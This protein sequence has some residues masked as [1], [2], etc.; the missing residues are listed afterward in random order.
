VRILVSKR[1]ATAWTRHLLGQAGPHRLVDHDLLDAFQQI[2]G[3]G[4]VQSERLDRQLITFDLSHLVYHW[5]VLVI[6][7][8]GH[9][10]QVHSE[11]H[12]AFSVGLA[13]VAL[14]GD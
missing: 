1:S 13:Q 11:L 3:F 12:A 4:Q 9:D 6:V 7:V 2:F 10:D 8:F 14:A 5:R